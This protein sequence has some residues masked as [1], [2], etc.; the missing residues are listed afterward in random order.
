[1]PVLSAFFLSDLSA[2]PS[3]SN[4]TSSRCASLCFCI[5]SFSF[6]FSSSA[7]CFSFSFSCFCFNF[8]TSLSCLSFCL[9][10]S[11]AWFA[12]SLAAATASSPNI[13]LNFFVCFEGFVFACASP[14]A[15]SYALESSSSFFAPFSKC[16]ALS[17]LVDFASL[18]SPFLS[19]YFLG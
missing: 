19:K 14:G 8:S 5:N 12:F 2:A 6:S 10:V 4:S 1:M 11:S 3:S 7:F 15:G 16:L 18:S 9:S 13:F 17:C